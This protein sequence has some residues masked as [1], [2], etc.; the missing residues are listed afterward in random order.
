MKKLTL[1][2]KCLAA[3]ILITIVAM[4][5]IPFVPNLFLHLV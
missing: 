1:L 2:E 5:V 4:I 3:T